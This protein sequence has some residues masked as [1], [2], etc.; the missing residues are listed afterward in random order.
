[1]KKTAQGLSVSTVADIIMEEFLGPCVCW[2]NSGSKLITDVAPNQKKQHQ[3]QQQQNRNKQNT[4]LTTRKAER[5]VLKEDGADA[6]EELTDFHSLVGSER[7]D[8]TRDET[9]EMIRASREEQKELRRELDMIREES[10]RLYAENENWK[11]LYET[12]KKASNF[13]EEKNVRL[14]QIN[15]KLLQEGESLQQQLISM[16]RQVEWMQREQKAAV[17]QLHTSVF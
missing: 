14:R 13:Q 8:T 7:E 16:Q 9:E 5:R 17:Q 12:S 11:R 3:Q 4:F 10:E 6:S 15:Q 2:D 1:M